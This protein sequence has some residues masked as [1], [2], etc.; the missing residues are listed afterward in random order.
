MKYFDPVNIRAAIRSTRGRIFSVRFI[1]RTSG[2]A[3]KMVAR[4]QVRKYITGGGLTFS[5]KKRNLMVVF[6]MQKHEYRM[7]PL[8]AV[9]EFNGQRA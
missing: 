2:D 7:I 9:T 3:R 6:D 1:K 8:D 5:P 4:T